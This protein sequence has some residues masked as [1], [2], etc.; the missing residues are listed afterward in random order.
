M[1]PEMLWTAVHG[2]EVLFEQVCATKPILLKGI[3]C[4]QFMITIENKTLEGNY[5]SNLFIFLVFKPA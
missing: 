4:L 1:K 2:A 3:I 5:C